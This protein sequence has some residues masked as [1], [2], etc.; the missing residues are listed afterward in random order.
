MPNFSRDTLVLS[1]HTIPAHYLLFLFFFFL[2]IRPPPRSTLFPYTTLF[3]SLAR[4]QHSQKTPDGHAIGRVPRDDRDPP[5]RGV[6]RHACGPL[7]RETLEQAPRIVDPS[8]DVIGEGE[9]KPVGH[10]ARLR[11]RPALQP[12]HGPHARGG[13]VCLV[14]VRRQLE[15]RHDGDVGGRPARLRREAGRFDQSLADVGG[16]PQGGERAHL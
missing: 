15:R 1:V 8:A 5:H 3:R 13:R 7:R 4:R 6:V 11:G 12:P 14:I 10:G 16:P 9:T 2:I